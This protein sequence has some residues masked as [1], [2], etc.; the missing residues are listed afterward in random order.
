M[1]SNYFTISATLA[2]I[3]IVH[4]ILIDEEILD[5][6]QRLGRLVAG[7]PDGT[8][9]CNGGGVAGIGTIRAVDQDVGLIRGTRL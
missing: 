1:A 7:T 9:S 2:E 4:H 6:T 3:N 8:I 5:L